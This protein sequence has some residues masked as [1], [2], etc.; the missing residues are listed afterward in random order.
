MSLWGILPP[1]PPVIY[2]MRH[3]RSLELCFV[4]GYYVLLPTLGIDSPCPQPG[5]L[6][7][8]LGCGT[9][10]WSYALHRFGTC[11]WHLCLPYEPNPQQLLA[12][13]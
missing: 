4:T 6:L 2:G 7:V 1:S 13:H 8:R 10:L 11:L 9:D 3:A 5:S 12:L